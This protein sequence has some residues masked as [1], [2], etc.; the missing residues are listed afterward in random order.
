MLE[1]KGGRGRDPSGCGRI[2]L[3]RVEMCELT[4]ENRSKHK[5]AASQCGKL[6]TEHLTAR[7]TSVTTIS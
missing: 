1:G 5:Q 3:E 6:R 7:V 2:P 4:G